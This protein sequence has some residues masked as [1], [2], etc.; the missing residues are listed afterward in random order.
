[1]KLLENLIDKAASDP[2]ASAISSGSL[3]TQRLSYQELV[4]RSMEVAANLDGIEGPVYIVANRSVELVVGI[5]AALFSGVAAAIIDPRQGSFRI[6]QILANKKSAHVMTD[7]LGE[8]LLGDT[9]PVDNRLFLP[10]LLQGSGSVE[11][12]PVQCSDTA[13]SVILFTSGSTGQPKGV[14]ISRSDLDRRLSTENEWFQLTAGE[15][16]LGVLPLSFDVGLTQLLGSLYGGL[17]H[18]LVSSWLPKDILKHVV[19]FDAVGLALSPIVWKGLLNSPVQ[20]EL[21]AAINSMRYVTL[22]GGGLSPAELDYIYTKLS[23]CKLIK[24]YGQTEMFRISSLKVTEAPEKLLSV[25]RA[26]PGVKLEVRDDSG[27]VCNHNETGVI[28]ASGDGAMLG[29]LEDTL[30]VNEK[31]NE[32]FVCTGDY[33][34]LDEHGYLYIKGRKDE[35]IKIL[36]QRVFPDDVASSLQVLLQV[37]NVVVV[38]RRNEDGEIDLVAFFLE[39]ELTHDDMELKRL[40]QRNLASHMVPKH[41]YRVSEFPVTLSGKIDKPGLLN[42]V[43]PS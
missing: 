17:H 9:I 30:A 22:S 4:N 32:G 5:I 18:V 2:E 35:M 39:S 23:S 14:C 33:G 20:E 1:M 11:R 36:D 31:M 25:G 34:Y 37:K 7:V 43:S 3:G 42:S 38:S 13:T 27:A 41:I 24:T 29:Y 26:Y 40:M 12:S 16:N 6:S 19:H 15:T 8:R 21:W 28:W 10:D